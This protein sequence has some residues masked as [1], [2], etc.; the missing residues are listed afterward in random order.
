MNSPQCKLGHPRRLYELLAKAQAGEL[1]RFDAD[2]MAECKP[3]FDE[4]YIKVI[5]VRDVFITR[6]GV[7]LLKAAGWDRRRAAEFFE[8]FPDDLPP[9]ETDK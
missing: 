3:L 1:Q 8:V 2:A 4:G 7:D 5:N 6:K 9:L